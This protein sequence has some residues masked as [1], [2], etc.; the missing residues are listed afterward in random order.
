MMVRITAEACVQ[1]VDINIHRAGRRDV[2]RGETFRAGLVHNT[3][4]LH[5]N[6]ELSGPPR[7]GKG[8]A[9][10]PRRPASLPYQKGGNREKWV[11]LRFLT[12]GRD[13]FIMHVPGNYI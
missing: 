1:Q 6:Y 8:H 10:S 12:H 11:A 5:I 3:C 7:Q 9:G 2:I 4:N 13:I